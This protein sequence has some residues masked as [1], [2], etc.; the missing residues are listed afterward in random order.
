M[1]D[2]DFE[3]TESFKMMNERMQTLAIEFKDCRSVEIDQLSRLLQDHSEKIIER[4]DMNY[5]KQ[6]GEA[7][8]SKEEL[9]RQDFFRSLAF[10]DMFSRKEGIKP[11]HQETFQWIFDGPEVGT[12]P[13]ENFTT[14][15]QART[16]TYWISGKAGSGKSTLMQFICEDSRTE[17]G[18]RA[19][20]DERQKEL[21]RPSFFFWAVGSKLQRSVE[22]FLRSVIYQLLDQ[23]DYLVPF[24]S[25]YCQMGPAGM[26][27]DWTEK[28]SLKCLEILIGEL[29]NLY[30]ICLFADGL[31][32]FDGEYDEL[33]TLV[34]KL[35]LNSYF[36]CCF[37]SRPEN[38][39]EREFKFSDKLQLQDLTRRDIQ[40]YV[41]SKLGKS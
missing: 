24:L 26:V 7:E 2:I 32:E 11:A 21:S 40:S 38:E 33:I 22:G 16:G 25:Q 8:K 29:S 39:F 37:S 5:Q 17:K 15:L 9:L 18:L 6:K 12:K 10:P 28:R 23:R 4:I 20:A 1:N 14:W 27:F 36:K 3:H 13:W 34:K 30:A 31:D 35:V 19:W 41:E